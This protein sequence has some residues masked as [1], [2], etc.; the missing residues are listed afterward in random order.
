MIQVYLKFSYA[1]Y[2][3]SVFSVSFSFCLLFFFYVMFSVNVQ[4]PGSYSLS[5]DTCCVM[6]RKADGRSGW[7]GL[8]K[9]TPGLLDTGPATGPFP[10]LAEAQPPAGVW[11]SLSMLRQPAG[12][13]GRGAWGLGV[14]CR[15]HTSLQE[16]SPCHR[17][18]RGTR[19]SSGIRVLRLHSWWRLKP[20]SLL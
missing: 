12:G 16:P 2:M 14:E 8:V 7:Q 9:P 13:G 1:A 3:V 17:V 15:R 20:P 18:C 11:V 10:L 5:V 4:M 19:R 6:S